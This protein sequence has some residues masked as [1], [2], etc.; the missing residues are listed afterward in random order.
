MI[1]FLTLSIVGFK[2]YV[3]PEYKNKVK[4]T[5]FAIFCGFAFSFGII[6]F[7][8][9]VYNHQNIVIIVFGSL[10][11]ILFTTLIFLVLKSKKHKLTERIIYYKGL[12]IRSSFILTLCLVIILL[13]FDFINIYLNRDNIVLHSRGLAEKYYEESIE[14][15]NQKKNEAGLSSAK[16]AFNFFKIGYEN[17]SR[18]EKKREKREKKRKI[19]ACM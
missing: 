11:F 16:K 18:E 6:A 1:V 3:A 19:H 12:L 5:L 14:L 10:N 7:G 15:T 17:D 8:A 13:P 4:A 9:K 2:L